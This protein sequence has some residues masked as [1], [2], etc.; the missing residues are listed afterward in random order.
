MKVTFK[1]QEERLNFLEHICKEHND[2]SVKQIK[3]KIRARGMKY[4][5][6]NA[7]IMEYLIKYKKAV[8]IKENSFMKRLQLSDN[9]MDYGTKDFSD[10]SYEDLSL[11]ERLIYNKL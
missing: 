4:S 1:Q 9:E 5:F 11:Q 2:F 10:L 3:D 8:T 7:T 6:N